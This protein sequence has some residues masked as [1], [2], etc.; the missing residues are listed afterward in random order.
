MA[1]EDTIQVIIS[2]VRSV[3]ETLN[4]LRTRQYL[5]TKQ[6]IDSGS[7]LLGDSSGTVIT[8]SGITYS[9]STLN[10]PNIF[11]TT[12]V[13]TPKLITSRADSSYHWSLSKTVATTHTYGIA[14]SSTGEFVLDSITNSQRLVTIDSTNYLTIP[15]ITGVSAILTLA[16]RS[17]TVGQTGTNGDAYIRPNNGGGVSFLHLAGGAYQDPFSTSNVAAGAQLLL[18]GNQGLWPGHFYLQAGTY[19]NNGQGF[20]QSNSQLNFQ[21]NNVNKI[22]LTSDT[23]VWHEV[24]LQSA[25]ANYGASFKNAAYMKDAAGIVHLRGLIANGASTLGALL[26]ALPSGYRPDAGNQMIFTTRTNGGASEI[27]IDSNGN[28]TFYVGSSTWLSL[29]GISFQAAF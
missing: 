27:R 6:V 29:D 16:S 5:T 28:V 8:D 18:G 20:I 26:F 12:Q 21:I 23:G 2:R 25:W 15:K 3:E 7:I 22:T 1:T 4:D 10:V 17:V 13:T 14:I 11:T 19:N 24:T 9:S